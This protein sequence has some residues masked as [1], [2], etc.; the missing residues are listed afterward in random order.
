MATQLVTVHLP[1][2]LYDRVKQ[3]AEQ[4]HRSIEDEL[5]EVIATAVPVP[6]DLPM[7]LVELL[8]TLN[9]FSDKELWGAARSYL[10]TEVA[11]ELEL[12]NDK[13]QREGLT[14]T[15]EH[16]LNLLIEQYERAM[17]I[18]AQAAAILQRRGYDI[19]SLRAA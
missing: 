16:H 8:T 3:R 12:L 1:Q 10:P 6:N 2:S 5:L 9:T 15:E 11:T 18:R 13:L 7:D 19:S 17:L 14:L 4:T